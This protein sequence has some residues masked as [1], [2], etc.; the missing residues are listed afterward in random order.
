MRQQRQG[1]GVTNPSTPMNPGRDERSMYVVPAVFV[2]GEPRDLLRGSNRE[3]GTSLTPVPHSI[4]GP[5]AFSDTAVTIGQ[6]R[7]SCREIRWR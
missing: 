1:S 7:G 2:I 4:I 6:D 3:K 5:I